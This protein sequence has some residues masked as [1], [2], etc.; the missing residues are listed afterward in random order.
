L[1][2]QEAAPWPSLTKRNPGSF[3]PV[4]T[5]VG[6]WGKDVFTIKRLEEEHWITMTGR[7]ISAAE[8]KGRREF[9]EKILGALARTL[10]QR[11]RKKE[12][13]VLWTGSVPRNVREKKN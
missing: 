7:D 5:L 4:G 2:I 6:T 9:W 8:S 11:K 3:K 1:T 10:T 13:S 12:M